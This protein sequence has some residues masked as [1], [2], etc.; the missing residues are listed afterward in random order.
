[1]SREDACWQRFLCVNSLINSNLHHPSF[2]PPLAH[3]PGIWPFS[4]PR[5]G[6][7]D[8]KSLPEGGGFQLY[9]GGMGSLNL[10]CQAD[11]PFL[12]SSRI[13]VVADPW[14]SSRGKM[15]LLWVIDSPIRVFTNFVVFSKVC[16]ENF[17]ACKWTSFHQSK[18]SRTSCKRPL[19]VP[20]FNG[21][22]PEVV[23]AY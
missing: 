4:M 16:N 23:I 7:Y 13:H 8:V 14:M 10:K 11:W 21:R 12:L 18:Y 15:S 5:R 3:T 1:M 20:R 22:L 19:K 9:L 17:I 6:E 2:H